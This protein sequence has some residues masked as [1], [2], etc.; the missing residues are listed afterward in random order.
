PKKRRNLRTKKAAARKPVFPPGASLQR[1]EIRHGMLITAAYTVHRA[2]TFVLGAHADKSSRELHNDRVHG[3]AVAGLCF[4]LRHG[5]VAA[6][7]EHVLHLHGLD[8]GQ[9]LAGL[10]L[11]PRPLT[12]I[13]TFPVTRAN[14]GQIF[15]ASL[16][17]TPRLLRAP[18]LH[19]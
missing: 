5:D 6:G 13:A 4:E 15:L 7:L 11:L 14:T 10:H 16:A 18:T 17:R 3:K 1:G 9:R 2:K 12:K 19:R 8:D